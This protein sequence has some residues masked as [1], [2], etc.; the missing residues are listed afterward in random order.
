MTEGRFFR[1]LQEPHKI[2]NFEKQTKKGGSM[3]RP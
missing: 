1:L 2:G 3:S